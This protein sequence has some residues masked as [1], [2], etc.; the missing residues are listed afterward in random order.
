M[1]RAILSPNP[2]RTRLSS[3]STPATQPKVPLIFVTLSLKKSILKY[4]TRN[5]YLIIFSGFSGAECFPQRGRL[6]EGD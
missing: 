4:R 6:A 5:L 1:S 2:V 3:A